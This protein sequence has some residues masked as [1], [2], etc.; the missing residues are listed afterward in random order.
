[1]AVKLPVVG[2]RYRYIN[3]DDAPRGLTFPANDHGFTVTS[4]S[5]SGGAYTKD[6]LFSGNDVGE[7]CSVP[8]TERKYI[9]LI[10]EK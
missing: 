4:M 6:V 8:F 5:K 1:M 2:K 3:M 9:E 10:K 7:L